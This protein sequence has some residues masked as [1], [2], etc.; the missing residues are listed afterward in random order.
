M[1]PK[2]K[3]RGTPMTQDQTMKVMG[4]MMTRDSEGPV[5]K[6]EELSGLFPVAVILKRITAYGLPFT[7]SNSFILASLL[8]GMN[9][10]GKAMIV[11][12][13]AFQYYK[14]KKSSCSDMSS[15]LTIDDWANMFPWGFPSDSEF[16][17]MWE[18]Q[19]SA[20]EP[21]GNLVDNPRHW[22]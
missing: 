13:L 16:Q 21:H 7:F 5:T 6:D 19:K 9:S 11:L 20:D 4:L 14:E 12:A 22:V 10:P 8:C 1:L 3:F 15:L 18:S 2:F 17:L